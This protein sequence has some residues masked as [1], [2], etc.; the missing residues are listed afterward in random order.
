MY[1]MQR[2]RQEILQYLKTHG[3]AM[4]DELCEALGYLT[5]VTIRHHLDVLRSQGL[6]DTPRVRHRNTPGRPKYVYSLTK[7]AA[8]VFPK[9]YSRLT[10]HVF[11]E[12]KA[13]LDRRQVNVLFEG[14]AQRMAAAAPARRDDETFEEHLERIVAYLNEQGYVAGWEAHPDGGYILHTSN[15]PYD[16]VAGLHHELCTMDMSLVFHLLGVKPRR[17]EHIAAGDGGCAYLICPPDEA[18]GGHPPGDACKPEVTESANTLAE[19]N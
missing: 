12:I 8:E 18:C 3:E 15:C 17:I 9:N 13:N 10:D 6:V 5:A 14:V 2:A 19:N 7:Q 4:V 1:G 11:D 16:G